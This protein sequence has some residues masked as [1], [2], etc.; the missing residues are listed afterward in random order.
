[1]KKFV[2]PILTVV[3]VVSI[4]FAGCAGGTAP[5]PTAEEPEAEA[6]TTPELPKPGEWT[7]ATGSS[8]FTFTFTVNP[9]RTG[10][11]EYS[12]HFTEFKCEGVQTSGGYRTTVEPI[13][14]ITGGQ[15]TIETEERGLG[16]VRYTWDIVIQG[17]FDETG[18]QASG[19]WEISAEGTICAE[20][21]WEA[22]AP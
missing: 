22:S 18:T 3:T 9:D 16:A 21:A 5:A 15:F 12:Y 10:I 20:G 6:P 1:M 19:T 14:P 7:A 8:E 11:P 13:R 4:I 17:K 2:I